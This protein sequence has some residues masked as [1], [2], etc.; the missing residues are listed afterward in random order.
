MHVVDGQRRETGESPLADAVEHHNRV[1]DRV[2]HNG[3]QRRDDGHT[4]LI[5]ECDFQLD[6]LK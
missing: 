2:P 6:K 3:Q 5:A 1:V 4:Q